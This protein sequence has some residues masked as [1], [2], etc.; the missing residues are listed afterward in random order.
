MTAMRNVIIGTAGHIDHGKTAL[1]RALTGIDADRLAEEKRR[2]ITIDIGFAHLDLGEFRIGFID[3]PGHER[4]VKN[5]LAGIGGVDFVLLVVAADESVMPQ[6]IEHFQICR[7]LGLRRGVIVLT[8]SDTVDRE[9]KD[10]VRAEIEEL[11]QGSFL[12]GAPLVEVDSL[13]GQGIEQLRSVLESDLT[14]LGETELEFRRSSRTFLLPIDRVFSIKGFGTVLTG[15]AVAGRVS[16]NTTVR[17]LP[18]GIDAKIRGIEIFS[19][20]ADFAEAGQRTALNLSSIS[21][22]QLARGMVV[23]D[24][25]GG[26][27]TRAVD[28]LFQLLDSSP[29]LAH[30]APVRFHAGSAEIMGRIHLFG[31]RELSPGEAA[32]VQ[33]RLKDPAVLFPGDRFILRRYSPL[34]T[35]GGGVVLDPEPPLHRRRE[36]RST[37]ATLETIKTAVLTD[38]LHQPARLL[39]ALIARRGVQGISLVELSHRTGLI[40]EFLTSHLEMMEGILSVPS[41][42]PL[43]VS[44]ESVTA[45]ERTVLAEL[46][47][48]HREKPLSAGVSREELRRRHLVNGSSALFL[49][50]LERMRAADQVETDGSRVRLRGTSL[51]LSSTQESI[52]EA[53]LSRLKSNAFAELS[54]EEVAATTGAAAPAVREV[55]YFLLQQGQIVRISE[56]LWLLP[57]QITDIQ[58]LLE[59]RYPDRRSFSVPEFKDLLNVSRKYAIPLLEHL[60]REGFTRRTGDR[61]VVVG[62]TPGA[63]HVPVQPA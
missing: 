55:F 9:L 21:K 30:R 41:D 63:D 22:D 16:N 32:L 8:K 10:L 59:Q 3:V 18:P 11:V 17:I 54:L 60:D 5:M 62:A 7:L 24:A 48:H 6:T 2:G 53:I 58:G 52:R 25:K 36:R 45:W 43:F 23:V 40:P 12:E 27:T 1:V 57:S 14:I 31:R 50:L 34:T 28:T 19:R 56:G 42:P 29:P 61:R 51:R 49:S 38:G 37:L 47:R 46:E 20:P 39:S 4:F 44:A 26:R 15:T 13:S 33:L 35:V